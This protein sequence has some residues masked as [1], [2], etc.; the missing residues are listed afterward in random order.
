MLDGFWL[1][2]LTGVAVLWAVASSFIAYVHVR[3]CDEVETLANG[4]AAQISALRDRVKTL[5]VLAQ[6]NGWVT[7]VVVTED[8]GV[9]DGRGPG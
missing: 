1:G 8:D 4:Q 7:D 3:R 6:A 5:G 9:A 2:L